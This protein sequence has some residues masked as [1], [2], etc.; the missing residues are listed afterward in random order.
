MWK[1]RFMIKG[2]K[3]ELAWL[4]RMAQRH[5][6]LVDIW[7]SWYHFKRVTTTYHLFSE[8]VPTD[9]VPEMAKANQMFKV[10]ATYEVSNPDIQ[11]VY[12]GTDQTVSTQVTPGDPQMRL[13]VGLRMRDQ[14]LNTVNVTIYSVVGFWAVLLFLVISQGGSNLDTGM[15]LWF[16]TIMIAGV[17]VFRLYHSAKKLQ[18]QIVILRRDTNDYDGAWMPTMHV[19]VSPLTADLDTSALK[20]L[21]RWSLVNRTNKGAYWYDLQTLASEAEIK[22]SLKPYV[23]PDSKVSVVS[24]LGLAPLGWFM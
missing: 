17:A 19:F 21:G 15:T 10:L 24:W 4:N 9:L 20:S 13:K 6:L 18:D 11:V 23:E 3:Q 7:N 12:T 8:Y 16:L 1:H 5:Y 22:T 14:A 2:S